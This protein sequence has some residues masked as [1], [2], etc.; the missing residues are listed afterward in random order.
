MMV[1]GRKAKVLYGAVAAAG[2]ALGALPLRAEA[3]DPAGYIGAGLGMVNIP[4]A[5]NPPVEGTDTSLVAGSIYGGARLNEVIAIEV[6]YM[7]SGK[8]DIKIQNVSTGI[9]Y[10]VDAFYGAVVARIPTDGALTP[11][12]KLGMHRYEIGIVA[13]SEGV[14]RS[15]SIDGTELL[16]GG[17]V[18]WALDESW[19]LRAEYMHLPYSV[20]LPAGINYD[21]KVHA[22][23]V[24]VH[25]SF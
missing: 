18:D 13:M 22:F 3:A 21:G 11:F 8:G 16:L 23:L 20:H 17:G 4:A 25:R 19:S 24:G 12:A 9:D 10:D 1:T 5:D 14:R 15:G 7:K 6:G 2:L